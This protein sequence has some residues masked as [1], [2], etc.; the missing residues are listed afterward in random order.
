MPGKSLEE[1]WQKMQKEA[2]EKKISEQKEIERI[3]EAREIQR[4][5]WR[6]RIKM[7]ESVGV[8]SVASSSSAGGTG[9]DNWITFYNT[10]WIYPQVDIETGLANYLALAVSPANTYT[11]NG[12]N[13]IF[14]TLQKVADFFDEMFSASAIS[15]PGGNPG[16]SLAINTRLQGLRSQILFMLPNGHVVCKLE[17]MQQ[18]TPQSQLPS[19]GNSIDGTIGYG[20]IYCDWDLDGQQDPVENTP[21]VGTFTDPLRFKLF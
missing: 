6:Q 8:G 10:A 9:L 1:I 4:Q 12:N 2:E 11:Q 16:Y 18:I 13:Y 21:P 20:L 7:Y 14:P 3:N 5:E 19:G 17:L 15:N